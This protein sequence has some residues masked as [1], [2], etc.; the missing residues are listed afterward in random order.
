VA[1]ERFRREYPGLGVNCCETGEQAAEGADAVV[2]VTEWPHY[3]DMDWEA[4]A[5]SMRTRLVLDG[6]NVLDR[7]RL[8]RAGFH[9][10]AMNGD[11]PA[12]IE[13]AVV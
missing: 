3:R 8:V 4:L 7:V 11:A 5:A 13:N 9:Y 1:L 2:L 6:R 10:L 12:V